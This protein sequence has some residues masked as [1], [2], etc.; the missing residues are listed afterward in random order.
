MI[1]KVGSGKTSLISALL[2]EMYNLNPRSHIYLNS[3]SIAYV[4]QQAWIKNATLKQNI[5]FDKEYEED[6]YEA[7]IDACA[8]RSDLELMPAGDE[9]EIGE[10]GIN[11][12]GGQKQ[13]ISLA[14]ALYARY[15]KLTW[16]SCNRKTEFFFYFFI[17]S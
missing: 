14:R 8:L 2:G 5:L 12:S 10:K 15:I 17:K 11:L 9:T 6:L 3:S 4:P 16:D 1:G 13:R 7:V